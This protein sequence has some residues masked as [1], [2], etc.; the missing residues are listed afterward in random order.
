VVPSEEYCRKFLNRVASPTGFDV[1]FDYVPDVYFFV[2][3]RVGRFV[4]VNL[5]F[6]KLARASKA[7][8][9]IGGRDSDFFPPSLAE[10]YMKD[11]QQVVVSSAPMI[12]K[13]EL[14]RHPDGRVE[15]FCTTK[16]PLFDRAGRA[17]GICG[18]TRD[19]KRMNST[20]ARYL[21]WAP[22]LETLLEE[23]GGPLE[24]PT[25]ARKMALSVSQFNR[26]FKRRF[27][28]TPRAYLTDVRLKAACHFLAT[29]D[30]SMSEIALQTGFYDQS[31][32][33]NQF[34]K[35]QGVTPSKYR[36]AHAQTDTLRAPSKEL[37]ATSKE[38]VS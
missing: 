15:W 32:F 38:G 17:I 33:T 35:H 34:V 31:H 6:S 19:V 7:E 18:I 9:V 1:L 27:H 4:R 16:L 29:T 12:D 22:V 3:D 26:Q 11:D 30:L 13:A 20:H 14:M 24:I 28:T 23:Y 5:A 25:L 21:S 37:T 10:N 2:K 8:E 36:A